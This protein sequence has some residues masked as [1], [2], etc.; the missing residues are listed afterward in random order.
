MV[1]LM[2]GHRISK[3]GFFHRKSH[4]KDCP[5]KEGDKK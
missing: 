1:C 2:C 4:Y 5:A 3:W